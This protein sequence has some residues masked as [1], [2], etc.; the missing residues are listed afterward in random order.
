M[1]C[2][3]T[4][5]GRRPKSGAADPDAGSLLGGISLP[6]VSGPEADDRGA[7]V[8]VACPLTAVGGL[9]PQRVI[10]SGRVCLALFRR[11]WRSGEGVTIRQD[12]H[13]YGYQLAAMLCFLIFGDTLLGRI[14]GHEETVWFGLSLGRWELI[15]VS[16][17]LGVVCELLFW[18]GVVDP[19]KRR[20]RG[21]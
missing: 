18:R 14:E 2:S 16:G 8:V 10:H 3:S 19:G 21:E 7:L 12:D 4:I 6:G 1:G 9:G 20:I 5:T 17:V 11:R 13:P 15:F